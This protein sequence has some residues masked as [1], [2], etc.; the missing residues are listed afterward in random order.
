MLTLCEKTCK[1]L[2][3]MDVEM[4]LDPSRIRTLRACYWF[5]ICLFW[6]LE[7]VLFG[8]CLLLWLLPRPLCH[9]VQSP[10]PLLLPPVPEGCLSPCAASASAEG[11]REL[12]LALCSTWQR[13]SNAQTVV[14]GLQAD[15]PVILVCWENPDFSKKLKAEMET[16]ACICW[17]ITNMTFPLRLGGVITTHIFVFICFFQAS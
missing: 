17:L 4:V 7:P 6:S 12:P 8:V 16:N 10:I 14:F 3:L 9:P 13:S 2:C 11:H 1:I 15:F 5:F